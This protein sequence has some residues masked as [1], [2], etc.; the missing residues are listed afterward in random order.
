M[1][2]MNSSLR[3]QAWERRL[4][5]HVWSA[6]SAS[7]AWCST[8]S[9]ASESAFAASTASAAF[10][11]SA[12]WTVTTFWAVT[13]IATISGMTITVTAS[14]TFTTTA[15]ST[16]SSPVGVGIHLSHSLAIQ[17]EDILFLLGPLS[18]LLS[19]T[20]N[21]KG[22]FIIS[23]RKGGTFWEL[24]ACSLIGFAD[25]DFA[26]DLKTLL[27][28]FGEVILISLDLG[29]FR[30]RWASIGFA[31]G[32]LGGCILLISLCKILTGLFVIPS[33]LVTTPTV[34]GLLFMFTLIVSIA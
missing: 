27:G 32:I 4:V 22:F 34:F 31:I 15:A 1:W 9:V 33:S 14:A 3:S 13:T 17:F 6:A 25:F 8:S 11:A 21:N 16:A 12:L 24:L 20:A 30:L 7:T 26:T 28:L 23:A 5:R 18:V 29:G 2:E 10:A 19:T